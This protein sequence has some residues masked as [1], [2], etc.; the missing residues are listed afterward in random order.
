[1]K[2]K[3]RDRVE[4]IDEGNIYT[5]HDDMATLLHATKYEHG[6]G[7]DHSLNGRQGI[8]INIHHHGSEYYLV[9][10]GD[11]EI[12]IGERGIDR[13]KGGPREF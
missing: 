1:M 6:F 10:I 13:I 7:Y 8:I 5:T 2:Y 12:I 3:I 4:I 11:R 9:D